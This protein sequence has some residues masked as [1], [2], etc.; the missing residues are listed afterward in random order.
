ML[1]KAK[2][3]LENERDSSPKRHKGSRYPPHWKFWLL[4]NYEY[5]EDSLT[6][7]NDIVKHSQTE[8]DN[9]EWS[10]SLSTYTIGSIVTDI[11]GA[12]VKFVKR[13]PR[14]ARQR[15]YLNLKRVTSSLTA[16]VKVE[17]MALQLDDVS[18]PQGWTAEAR[19]AYRFSF[20]RREKTEFRGERLSLEMLVELPH[21]EASS[22]PNY[23]IKSH[24]CVLDLGSLLRID[25]TRGAPLT[26]EISLILQ[27]L[28]TVPICLGFILEEDQS[29]TSLSHHTVGQLTDLSDPAKRPETR[30]YSGSC[31]ILSNFGETCRNCGRFKTVN[32][33]S[34][35]NR[36][37]RKSIKPQ[38]NKRFL[39]REELLEEIRKEQRKRRNAE[40]RENYWREK[41]NSVAIE[42]DKEDH[43]DL[44]KCTPTH[45]KETGTT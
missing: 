34:Q 27:Y 6:F 5:S 23:K 10:N 16:A 45:N 20:F 18:L 1:S 9:R 15:A 14:N 29:I 41:F 35:K 31:Q 12:K 26:E 25:E 44:T 11:W 37:K 21:N 28:N 13:G 2:R 32:S 30:V 24:G 4:S 43:A 7:T 39:S 42:V 33:Q 19:S 36:S 17:E 8:K 3:S 38:R 22:R 40:L